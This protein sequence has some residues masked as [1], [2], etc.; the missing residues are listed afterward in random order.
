VS[1]NRLAGGVYLVKVKT[2]KQEKTI[3]LII[4]K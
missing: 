2:S 3:K 1:E 4:K